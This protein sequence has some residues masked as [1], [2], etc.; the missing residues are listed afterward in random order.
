MEIT[1][2]RKHFSHRPA[3]FLSRITIASLLGA[4]VC[5]GLLA[6]VAGTPVFV[7]TVVLLLIAA[8]LTIG[9]RWMPLLGSIAGGLAI[10]VFIHYTS[11]PLY[12][13]SHPKDALSSSLLSFG[14]F[15]DIVLIFLCSLLTCGAGLAATLQNYLHSI[16]IPAGWLKTVCTSLVGI[17]IGA[18]LIGALAQPATTTAATNDPGTVHLGLGGFSSSSVTLAKGSTLTLIDD[19]A[20]HHLLSNGSWVSG[21]P[22]TERE[23]SAP[24]V[25]NLDIDG[26]GKRVKIG[27]FNT[28]GTYHLYCSLHSG[29]NIT[30]IVQ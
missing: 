22:Q 13:L 11:L 6:L 18:L 17:F 30:I 7:I 12:H 14:L 10:Y 28:A 21:Q 29:M 23:A 27:P 24:L 19:G 20:F 8:L 15:A 9:L 25:N 16:Q 3:S 26:S 4:S 2:E 5:C 1:S